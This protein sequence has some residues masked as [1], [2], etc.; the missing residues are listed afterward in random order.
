VHMHI[1]IHTH[2]LTRNY[3]ETYIQDNILDS[4]RCNRQK[5]KFSYHGSVRW[6]GA[7]ASPFSVSVLD[8]SESSA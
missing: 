7:M 6:C 5:V 4:A 8:G 1:S 2:T 3:V